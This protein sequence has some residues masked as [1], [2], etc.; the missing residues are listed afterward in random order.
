MN[1]KIDLSL[2]IRSDALLYNRAWQHENGIRL[3]PVNRFNVSRTR[4]HGVAGVDVRAINC[5]NSG[6]DAGFSDIVI[7]V[8]DGCRVC[9]LCGA[10]QSDQLI[11]ELEPFLWGAASASFEDEK[12][13]AGSRGLC[14]WTGSDYQPRFH[15]N[16]DDKLRRMVGP[17]I[18]K[19]NKD[20]IFDKIEGMGYRPDMFIPSPKLVFQSACRQIDKEHDVDLYGRKFGENWI[21]LLAEFTN[22]RQT[23]PIPDEN[24]QLEINQ[25]FDNILYAWPMCS[26]LLPGSVQGRNR[27]QLPQYRWLY[28]MLQMTFYPHR[29]AQQWLDWLPILSEKKEKE[30]KVFWKKICFILGW[31]YVRLSSFIDLRNRRPS[32]LVKQTPGRRPS[33]PKGRVVR[34]RASQ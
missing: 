8:S 34:S 20:I 26:H 10:V 17:E 25:K 18:P 16:E 2:D 7:H 24:E 15:W 28:R 21:A 22:N 14:L 1:S 32:R 29:F 12:L 31:Q 11:Q 6:C 3:P 30:L 33:R 19:F 23:P 9:T 13:R 5:I 27:K 4:F